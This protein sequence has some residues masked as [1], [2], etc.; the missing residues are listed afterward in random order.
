M[1]SAELD[2]WMILNGYSN[3]ALADAL[4]RSRG[5]IIRW[6]RGRYPIPRDAA[7]AIG[8]LPPRE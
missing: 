5:T 6:R 3:T 8:S 7:L 2:A 1:T 4:E